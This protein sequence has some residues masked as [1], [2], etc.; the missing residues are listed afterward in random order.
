MIH[1][2]DET[3]L[4]NEFQDHIQSCEVCT[5]H[6]CLLPMC[7]V[8]EAA[9]LAWSRAEA[10]AVRVE[11]EA[12]ELNDCANEVDAPRQPWADYDDRPWSPE[13]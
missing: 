2:S 8:G 4:Y 12:A 5:R 9:Y 3:R 6:N 10:I 1:A 7:R 13:L 11:Q